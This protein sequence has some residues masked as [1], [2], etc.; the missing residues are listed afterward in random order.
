MYKKNIISLGLCITFDGIVQNVIKLGVGH[1]ET[2][3]SIIIGI[4][5]LRLTKTKNGIY[6]QLFA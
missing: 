1:K 6:V 5:L 3:R 2:T 4:M